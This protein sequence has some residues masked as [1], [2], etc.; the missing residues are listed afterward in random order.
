MSEPGSVICIKAPK[1]MGKSS[2]I[3]RLLARPNNQGFHTVTL[4]FQQADKAVF[5]SLDK[6]LCWFCTKVSREL[7]LEPKLNDY[8]DE[9]MG[10]KVSCS[11]YFQ[12][13]LLSALSSP[14]VLVLNE[15]D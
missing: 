12:E 6:F 11:I 4:D 9:D 1:K 7:Q 14:L 10:S 5:A 3:L 8:W 13:Y 15:V 2:L